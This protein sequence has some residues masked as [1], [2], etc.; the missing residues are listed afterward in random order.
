MSLAAVGD[1]VWAGTMI[2]GLN[3]IKGGKVES[4]LSV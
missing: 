3:V 2:S 1:E 4:R